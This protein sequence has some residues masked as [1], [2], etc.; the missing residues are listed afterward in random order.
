MHV[1]VYFLTLVAESGGI[2]LKVTTDHGTET[3]DMATY[4][5]QLSQ[6][7]CGI[8]FEE[9]QKHMHFTKSTHN[10]KIESLWSR[11]MKEHNRAFIDNILSHMEAGKYNQDN[12]IQRQ[13]V[14][15]NFPWL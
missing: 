9:A 8:T 10:Q 1:G 3:M 15:H 6:K 11:M 2:P 4:Q 13:V 12:E 5:M 14:T 7:Y